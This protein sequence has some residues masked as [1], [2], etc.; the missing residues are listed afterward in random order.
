MKPFRHIL[1]LVALAVVITPALLFAHAMLVRSEPAKDAVLTSPPAEIRLWFSEQPDVRFSRVDL[2]GPKG[3]GVE[4]GTLSAIASNGLR[5]PIPSKLLP[6]T[7]VVFWRTAASDGHATNGR[8]HFTVSGDTAVA[9]TPPPQAPRVDTNGAHR[10]PQTNAV[11]TPSETVTTST[12]VRWAEFIALLVVIGATIFRLVIVPAAKWPDDLVAE[13]SDR[14]RRLAVAFAVLLL[15][16]TLTR[17][18]SE[19]QLLPQPYTSRFA[20]VESLVTTTRWGVA[21]CI[22]ALGVVIALAGL[23]VARAGLAGWIV[24]A[25]GVV[26]VTVS[27]GLTGH[28]GSSSHLSIAMA[29][30]V[31]HQLAAGGWLGGLACVIIAGL[32]TTRRLDEPDARAAAVQLV[33]SYHHSAVECVALI[34]VSGVI[35]AALRLHAFSDLWTTPYGSML[36]RKLVFVV[37]ALAIGL[38]HWRR[39]VIP[40]W[41]D[42]TRARFNRTA[43]FELVVFA[44]IVAFTALLVSTPLPR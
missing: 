3:R 9:A 37:I 15:I 40:D 36:F 5:V 27:E 30:D 13:A 39:V 42:G 18:L 20:A 4:V 34:I 35:A 22:G 25:V 19:S 7:Y 32:R 44:V 43:T 12:A 26:M 14:A 11:I 6:G 38:Y 21:W 10:G 1:A 24:A 29:M 31:A 23:L 8:F 2:T 41:N 33:R 16:T 17:A 28:S